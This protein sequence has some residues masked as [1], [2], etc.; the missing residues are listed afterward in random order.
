MRQG[1]K[2]ATDPYITAS[3]ATVDA[4]IKQ[5]IG[6]NAYWFR[7]NHDGYGENTD[8]SN[9]DG[10]G[11]GQLWPI[12]SG[13]RGIYTVETGASADAYLT[14]MT[15]S[16]NASGFI[17]EQIWDSTPPSG[18]TA[19]T[20]TKSMDPLNWSMAEYVTLLYSAANGTVADQTSLTTGRYVSGAYTPHTGWAVDYNSANL[21]Q[22][23][24]LTIYYHGSLDN[25]AHVYLHWGE[26]GWT[27]IPSTDK[28]MIKR[29]DG[30]WQ[31]TISRADRRHQPQ[32][33]LQR[34]HQLGQQRRR[35]LE[36][37]HLRRARPTRR[38]RPR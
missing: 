17:P 19:G 35:Q 34:R 32:L 4:T 29:P 24:A 27:N 36:R 5:T 11:V 37:Q 13:E 18:F 16:E 3:I 1:V 8:G 21:A 30:F 20:P 22:G 15:A 2:P 26:N 23:K 31:T 10:T 6:G 28:P 25:S 7:Y 33:R 9:Y 12:F 38:L 14:A